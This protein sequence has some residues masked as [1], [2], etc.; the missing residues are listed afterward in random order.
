MT[1]PRF[2]VSWISEVKDRMVTLTEVSAYKSKRRV[3]SP[4]G[5]EVDA[6]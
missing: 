5:K 3:W 1:E 4:N 6:L 2:F